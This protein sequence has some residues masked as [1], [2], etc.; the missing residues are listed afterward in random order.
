MNTFDRL[1]RFGDRV[2]DLFERGVVALEKLAGTPLKS[3]ADPV[4]KPPCRGCGHRWENHP[5]GDGCPAYREG[6]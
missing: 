1:F 2:T 4:L 5:N 3:E 6:P